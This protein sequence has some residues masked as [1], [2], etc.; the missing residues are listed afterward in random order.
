M[1]PAPMTHMS[2]SANISGGKEGLPHIRDGERPVLS[3]QTRGEGGNRRNARGRSGVSGREH[4]HAERRGKVDRYVLRREASDCGPEEG[5]EM[6]S[7]L[8]VRVLLRRQVWRTAREKERA[9]VRQQVVSIKREGA[10]NSGKSRE[11]GERERGED[12]SMRFRAV[13]CYALTC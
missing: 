1:P 5:K 2:R 4:L 6:R 13:S 9:S 7:I 12:Q 11:K 10:V 3:L 8:D